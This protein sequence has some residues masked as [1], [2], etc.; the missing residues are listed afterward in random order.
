M[1]SGNCPYSLKIRGRLYF[2]FQDKHDFQDLRPWTKSSGAT[3]SIA[4][5]LYMVLL[6]DNVRGADLSHIYWLYICG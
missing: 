5:T 4:T 1:F 2:T 3:G 6:Q